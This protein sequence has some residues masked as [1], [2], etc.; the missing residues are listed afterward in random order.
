MNLTK[1]GSED[2]SYFIG[3]FFIGAADLLFFTSAF[4]TA[5]AKF[6]FHLK[7]EEQNVGENNTK[8]KARID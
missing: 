7:H 2:F 4:R 3:P 6:G 1:W 5:S 8:N